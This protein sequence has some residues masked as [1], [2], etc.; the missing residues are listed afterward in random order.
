MVMC[1]LGNA[2]G[3]KTQGE[4]TLAVA[5]PMNLRYSLGTTFIIYIQLMFSGTAQV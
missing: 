5:F 2:E 1:L 3:A 4:L